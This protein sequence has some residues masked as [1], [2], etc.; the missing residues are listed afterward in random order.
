MSTDEDIGAN[1]SR[2]RREVRLRQQDLADRMTQ[3]GWAWSQPIVVQIERGRRPVKASELVDLA[4]VLGASVP[5]LLG[6]H[7]NADYGQLQIESAS[8]AL[9]RQWMTL[10]EMMENYERA[11]RGLIEDMDRYDASKLDES[12]R[13]SAEDTALYRMV[14]LAGIVEFDLEPTLG[15][16]PPGDIGRYMTEYLHLWDRVRAD[17]AAEDAGLLRGR[18]SD[19]PDEKGE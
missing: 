9:M 10:R 14:D 5:M 11:R 2:M 12:D 1:I 4:S 6:R 13:L 7:A 19:T 15:Q 17:W 8:R 18:R 16:R 3:R